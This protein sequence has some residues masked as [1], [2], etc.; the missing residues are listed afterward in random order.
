MC[1]HGQTAVDDGGLLLYNFF[2]W[3]TGLEEICKVWGEECSEIEPFVQ[4]WRWCH[5]SV[6]LASEQ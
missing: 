5:M 2:P 1:M 3:T 6:S 4:V